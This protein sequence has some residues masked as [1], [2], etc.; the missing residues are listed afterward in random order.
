MTDFYKQKKALDELS[1]IYLQLDEISADTALDASKKA[2]KKRG[3]LAAAGDKEGA[4]KKAKQASTLY[5]KQ[6]DKRLNREAVSNWREDPSLKE[7]LLLLSV[8]K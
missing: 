3:Q 8:A 6:A 1:S 5:K 7:V 4:A 2:D